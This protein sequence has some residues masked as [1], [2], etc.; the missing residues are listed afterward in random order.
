MISK[1]GPHMTGGEVSL[2][3]IKGEREEEAGEREIGEMRRRRGMLKNPVFPQGSR[4]VEEVDRE[5]KVKGEI[6]V[7]EREVTG[8]A[9]RIGTH[10]KEAGLS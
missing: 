6:G 7:R 10:V 4:A 8:K 9:E 1:G 2:G 3:R 5:A